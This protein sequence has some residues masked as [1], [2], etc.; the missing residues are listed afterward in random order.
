LQADEDQV[1]GHQDIR[2]L[3]DQDNAD[4]VAGVTA[5]PAG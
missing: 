2:I 5:G 1:S 3:R 4:H